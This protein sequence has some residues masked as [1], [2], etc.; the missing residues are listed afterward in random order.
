MTKLDTVINDGFDGEGFEHRRRMD[1]IV[2]CAFCHNDVECWSETEE[3]TEGD[4]GKWHHAGYGPS[5][6]ECCQQA[7]IDTW[8]GCFR[9]DLRKRWK[10]TRKAASPKPQAPSRSMEAA[11]ES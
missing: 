8:D 5:T 10:R 1:C 6:G 7:Y 4:D 11:C 3:W 2:E 9:I